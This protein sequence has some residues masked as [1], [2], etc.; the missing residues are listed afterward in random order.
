LS[1]IT[2]ARKTAAGAV[3]RPAVTLLIASLA[4][5]LRSCSARSNASAGGIEATTAPCARSAPRR[6][7][8]PGANTSFADRG[9]APTASGKGWLVANDGG[10]FG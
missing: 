10:I 1:H 5:N 4:A 7:A 2:A 6:S 8:R 9:M 3:A